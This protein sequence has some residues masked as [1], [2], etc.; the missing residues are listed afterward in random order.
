MTS[1]SKIF[2]SKFIL[3][4][5]IISHS[6]QNVKHSEIFK[7]PPK[8]LKEA[9]LRIAP[10]IDMEKIYEIIDSVPAISDIDRKFFKE[11][12]KIRKELIIDKALK[13]I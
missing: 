13:D 5:Y 9:I 4:I 11:S 2:L 7:N 6:P 3:D 1:Q 10:K 8:D 12:I